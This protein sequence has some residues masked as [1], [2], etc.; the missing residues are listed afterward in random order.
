MTGRAVGSALRLLM[1]AAVVAA[2]LT[3]LANTISLGTAWRTSSASSPSSRTSS[4]WSR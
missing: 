1:A 2:I 4:A 3:Q